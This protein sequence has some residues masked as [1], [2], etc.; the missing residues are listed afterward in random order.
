MTRQE[1][2]EKFEKLGMDKFNIRGIKRVDVD[3]TYPEK[4]DV[5]ALIDQI[6]T[7]LGGN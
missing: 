5:N 4:I 6:K 2:Y 3:A 7:M 1:F